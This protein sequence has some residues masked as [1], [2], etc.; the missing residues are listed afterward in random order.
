VKGLMAAEEQLRG[1]VNSR[2]A[3]KPEYQ[4]A[5]RKV[6]GT[7]LNPDGVAKAIAAYER[8]IL[9]GNS[10]YDRFRAGD[11]TALP[12][13]A[14]RGLALFEGKARCVTC[15]AGFNFT[16]ESYHNLGIGMDRPNPDLGRHTVSERV[17]HKGAFKTP[18]L[19][20]VAR[21]PPY[22]HDGSMRSLA[23]VIAFY[24]RGGTP[25]PWLSGEI[26]PLGLTPDE[27]ADLVVFLQALTGEVAAEVS[28]PPRLPQ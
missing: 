27:Q 12:A 9:S 22:M 14:R 8:T 5:F 20:D 18:T 28:S 19:R 17:E 21:R 10:P 4:A 26:R 16:D 1:L 13:P 6:F 23:E 3:K 2:D 25:N 11:R 7:D 15:H 24:N